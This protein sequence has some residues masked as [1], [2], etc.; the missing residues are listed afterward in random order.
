LSFLQKLLFKVKSD[1]FGRDDTLGEATVDVDD[2]VIN[3]G[4]KVNVSLSNGGSLLVQKTTPTRFRLYARYL[5]Y[6]LPVPI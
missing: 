5:P 1:S 4:Q 2:Y 6:K 3:K